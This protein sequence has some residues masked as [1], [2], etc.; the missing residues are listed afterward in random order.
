[1][2]LVIIEGAIGVGKTTLTKYFAE[3]YKLPYEEEKVDTPLLGDFYQNPERWAFPLQ[4]HF[5]NTRFRDIKKLYNYDVALLDRSIF[6]DRLFARINYE[7]GRM[8]GI[9][10]ELYEDLFDNMM[11]DLNTAMPTKKPHLMVYLQADFEVVFGRML[12]RARK[13]EMESLQENYEYFK[14]L[15][16]RYD[17]YV[18]NEYD[19]SPVLVIDTNNLNT[20]DESDRQFIFEKIEA[21]LKTLGIF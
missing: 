3:Q 15:H 12:G 21:E 10:M 9:E 7:L 14:F 18:L 11:E 2:P 16:G 20:H 8:L 4:V 13:E 6:L 1:M 19:A 5:L 17:D